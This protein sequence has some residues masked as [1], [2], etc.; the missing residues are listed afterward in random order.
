MNL[1]YSLTENLLT[2]RTDDFSAQTHPSGSHDK[3]AI[4]ARM[5]QRGTLLTRT[6]ILAVLN[7]FDETI[8]DIM[9]E[10]GHVNLPLLNTSFSISG[11]FEGATDSFDANRHKLNINLTKGTLLREAEK[12]VKLEKTSTI[13]P[14]PQILEVKDSVSGKVN[15]VL[16]SKGVVELRGHNIKVEGDNTACGLYFVAE[17]GTELKAAVLVTNKPSSVVAMMP[18]LAAGKSYQIKLVTQYT[19]SGTYLKTPRTVVYNK[20]LTAQAEA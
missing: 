17:D 8:V 9:L 14:Q 16:T 18:A 11:V 7:G 3:E 12:K 10:G 15:E 2:E 5:L 13:V 4:I 20:S 6:D 19:G 1:K